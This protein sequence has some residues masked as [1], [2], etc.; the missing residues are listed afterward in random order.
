MTK[1]KKQFLLV[2]LSVDERYTFGEIYNENILLMNKRSAG[3]KTVLII[4]QNF[5]DYLMCL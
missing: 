4:I 1:N 2:N 3:I 5:F